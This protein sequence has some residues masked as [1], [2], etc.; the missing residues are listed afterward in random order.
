ME[1]RR[2]PS[3][4]S[5]YVWSLVATGDRRSTSFTWIVYQQ[6]YCQFGIWQTEYKRKSILDPQNFA[7]TQLQ[8]CSVMGKKTQEPQ[9]IIHR[10]IWN[11]ME[12]AQLDFNIAWD[13]WLLLFSFFKS[14][15]LELLS[16]AF[17]TLLCWKQVTFFFSFTAPMWRGTM[18]QDRP[19]PKPSPHRI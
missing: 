14:E 17:P 9:R 12:F 11:Q 3:S 7:N 5:T 1:Q 13:Q 4:T 19:Q 18:P 2:E 10:T 6:K 8:T 16:F 15:C